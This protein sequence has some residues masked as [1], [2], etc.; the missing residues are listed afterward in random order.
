[1]NPV[2]KGEIPDVLL[3]ADA[4]VIT[5][6][7]ARAFYN[8]ISPN[9][10]Y[11]YMAAGKPVLCAVPGQMAAMVDEHACGLTSTPEDGGALAEQ[12]LRLV[13]MTEAERA[14]MGD[15]GRALVLEQFSRPRLVRR[16]LEL[17]ES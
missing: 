11:D 12:V 1:M 2:P 16:F 7:D 17:A 15:R 10:L 13:Q 8:A 6:R 14:A 3:A 4:A 9:K 5:L